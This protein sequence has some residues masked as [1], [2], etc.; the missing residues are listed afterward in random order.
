MTPWRCSEELAAA[1]T[2]LG[3]PAKPYHGSIGP[4][5]APE[6]ARGVPAGR[7]PV[8]VATSAFGLGV[9]KGD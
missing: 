5:G 2:E 9:D 3:V 4:Q 1:L 6:Y 7:T 8:V